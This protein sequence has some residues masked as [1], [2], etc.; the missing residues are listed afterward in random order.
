MYLGLTPSP[1]PNKHSLMTAHLKTSSLVSEPLLLQDHF[2]TDL[3]DIKG[4]NPGGLGVSKQHPLNQT[5]CA[6]TPK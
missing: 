1:E 3:G 4:S 2:S 5:Q 6:V